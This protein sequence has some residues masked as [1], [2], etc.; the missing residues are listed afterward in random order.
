VRWGLVLGLSCACI[1]WCRQPVGLIIAG[2]VAATWLALQWVNWAPPGLSKGRTLGAIAGGFMAVHA[3]FL[4]G[5]L[6]SGAGS[7]WWYQNIVWPGKWSGTVPLG[8]G[9]LVTVYTHPDAAAWLLAFLL[10]AALPRLLRRFRPELP[11]TAILAY[12]LGLGLV[13][14]WR[15][16]A[17]LPLLALRDGGWTAL[18]PLIILGQ[19]AVSLGQAGFSR[20]TPKT[21][22]Y[23]LIAALA[24]V[25]LGSLLQYY[26]LPDSWHMLW[27]LAPAFGLGVFVFWRWLGWS[28]PVL[29]VVFAL[30]LLPGVATKAR[31]VAD[32]L[33]Q[34]WVTL[35]SPA[36][37]R[38]MKVLPAQ[39]RSIDQIADTM[40]LI[41][42]KSPDLPSILIGNDALVLTFTHNHF[43]PLPY[44][45]NWPGLA[46]DAASQQRRWG[47]IE[48][49][50][51]M[52]FFQRARWDTVN[53]FY[54]R[55]HYVP[56]LYATDEAMEIAVPQELAT[57]MG[58]AAYGAP[59][60]AAP[61]P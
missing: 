10:A 51:P 48:E 20:N 9:K 4:G 28:A 24:A 13:L 29:S 40:D 47:Y 59:L 15:H 17:V 42:R 55:A 53:D 37:L 7:A 44:Y 52:V 16:A 6:L 38:G 25:S 19:A 14:V 1:F 36:V 11:R 18:F 43:N 34:P 8:W 21:T 23:Y 56:L 12:Y 31:L 54:R 58:L 60:S 35:T 22:E 33:T 57:A 32:C 5:I 3:L 61:K 26:P 2:C 27:S 39:A 45:V 49:V 46:D 30:A 41:L 50:R